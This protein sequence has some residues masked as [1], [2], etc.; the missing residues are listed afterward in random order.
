MSISTAKKKRI[1]D[2]SDHRCSYC[3][4][5]LT[6]ATMTLDH[7]VP[8]SAAKNSEEADAESNL[9]IACKTC[10]TAKAAMSTKEFRTFVNRRNSELLKLESDRRAAIARVFEL[11]KQ[12]D[13]RRFVFIHHLRNQ[14]LKNF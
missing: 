4:Q 10:N 14:L 1:W 2:A 5:P 13:S 7:I 9:C 12:I 6:F 11:D 3:H 8:K